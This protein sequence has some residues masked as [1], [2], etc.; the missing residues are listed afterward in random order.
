MAISGETE[1]KLQEDIGL[2][3]QIPIVDTLLEVVCRTTGL[4]FAAIARVTEDRWVACAVRDENAFGL[5]AGGE[6]DLQTT[7]CCTIRDSRNPVIIEEVNTDPIYATHPTPVMYGFQSYISVPIFRRDG[8]F[9]GTLCAIDPKS[10]RLNTTEILGMFKLFTDLISFHLNVAEELTLKESQISHE[11]KSVSQQEQFNADLAFANENLRL[12]NMELATTQQ[13]LEQSVTELRESQHRLQTILDTMAEGVGITDLDGQL[14]YANKMA[15]QILGLK[16]DKEN[17]RS[18]H[19]PEWHNFRLDGSALAEQDH[20]MS[21]MLATGLAVYDQEIAVQPPDRERFY[22]SINAAP[23]LDEQGKVTGGIGTFMDVTNRRKLMLQKDEF[24][25][26]ASHELKTPL[27]SLKVSLQLL[28]QIK[29][30]PSPTLLVRLVEQSN[31]SVNKL[32]ALVNDLLNV[33]RISEGQLHL[34]KSTFTIAEMINDCCQHIRLAGTHHITLAGDMSLKINADEQQIDQVMANLVNNAVKYAPSSPEILITINKLADTVKVTVKDK[35]PGI[36]PEKLPHL[37]DRYYRAD[38]SGIQ[39]SGLGL[40]LYISAEII[41]KHGGQ[42]GV[43][44]EPGHG[45]SF[46]FTLPLNEIQLEREPI[47]PVS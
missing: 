46:Y 5:V 22:I 17:S 45:T 31:K 41:R 37:F 39:F 34:R 8:S 16:E 32:D 21:I 3:S 2:I 7:I 11:K 10:A 20:P 28:D 40:G 36:Q 15:Q 9:F 35:G 25:S 1:Y 18:Y 4:G 42:I 44:S 24:I 6:L 47:S 14:V 23:I 43:V 38:Y 19:H 26:V 13:N 29:D 30:R 33:N 12:A 27:T